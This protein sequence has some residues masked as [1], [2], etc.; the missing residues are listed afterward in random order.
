ML[1]FLQLVKHRTISGSTG[2]TGSAGVN[3]VV[4]CKEGKTVQLALVLKQ[5]CFHEW[6]LRARFVPPPWQI[7]TDFLG[8]LSED[9]HA[10]SQPLLCHKLILYSA[11][12]ALSSGL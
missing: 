6:K 5:K 4:S 8:V 11:A 9:S 7:I 1:K 2:S 3:T 10:L 12:A